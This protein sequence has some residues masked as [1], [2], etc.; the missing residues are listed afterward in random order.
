MKRAVKVQLLAVM[1]MVIA[2]YALTVEAHMYEEDYTAACDFAASFSCTEVFKSAY[3]HPLS[4]LGLV[5]K[6]SDLDLG[7]ARFVGDHVQR[8]FGVEFFIAD[9]GCDDP[10]PQ[11]HDTG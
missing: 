2:A 10:V 5:S 4:H 6:D 11:C 8:A 3:A 1:G 9:G 7:L